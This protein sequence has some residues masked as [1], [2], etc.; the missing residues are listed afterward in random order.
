M[1]NQDHH[2]RAAKVISDIIYLNL[3]TVSEGGQPWN[4]P[5]YCAY[6]SDLNFYWL[7]WKENQHSRN[8]EDNG[9][10][11]ATIYDSTCPE[12]TGF[13]VYFQGKATKLTNILEITKAL[14][15]SYGRKSKKARAAEQ[16]LTSYPRRVYKF[17]PEKAWVNGDD[18]MEKNFIDVRHELNLE[19]LKDAV[20]KE[21]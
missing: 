20:A 5:V 3:A 15:V 19:Q 1:T 11:F 10:V 17:T 9:R 4:T 8:I 7:S 18:Y 13:G 2:S 6:D 12:S 21:K 14:A 16:F